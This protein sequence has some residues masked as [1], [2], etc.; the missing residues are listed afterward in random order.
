MT[1]Q[2]RIVRM[3][4]QLPA[5]TRVLIVED[6]PF[7]AMAVADM[8]VTLGCEVAAIASTVDEALEAVGR[9]DFTVVLLDMDLDGQSSSA[10]ASALVAAGKPFLVATGF[11]RRD[12]F[13][14]EPLLMKP[15]LPGQLGRGLADLL[16]AVDETHRRRDRA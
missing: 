2:Q 5:G 16:G 10:V 15:Y 14:T 1:A 8:I 3:P 12:G 7:I 4:P 11:G 13:D 9:G 6:H